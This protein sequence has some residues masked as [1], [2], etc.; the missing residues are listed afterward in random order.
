MSDTVKMDLQH[1][2][3]DARDIRNRMRI[4]PKIRIRIP[5][6]FWLKFWRWPDCHI[7][8]AV[9]Q[10]LIL[11]S[12]T[13]YKNT[14][15]LLIRCYTN[16]LY[17]FNVLLELKNVYSSVATLSTSLIRDVGLNTWT[18]AKIW[19]SKYGVLNSFPE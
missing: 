8:V 6:H 12:T 14:W 18:D 19:G 2:E 9:M 15:Q 13:T 5:D 10:F 16:L 3:T 1:F 11:H 7:Y 4:N 17:C